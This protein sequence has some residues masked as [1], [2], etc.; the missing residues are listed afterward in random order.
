MMTL[1]RRCIFFI[2][3]LLWVPTLNA[4]PVVN[5]PAKRII[6]L[7]PHSVELLFLLDAGERIIATTSFADYPEAAKLIPVIG[8]YNGIQI[9]KVLALKPDLI[10]A[11][12]G[13]N[14]ADDLAQLERLGFKVYRSQTRNLEGIAD[15]LVR[16]GELLGLS[17]RA[18]QE[19]DKFTLALAEL[20]AN[21]VHK[22]KLKFFYQ[23]WNEP[24]RA[25]AG[26]SWINEMIEICGG[27]NI[28]DATIGDYPQVSIETVLEG[29]PEVI[30]IPSHHGH[31]LGEGDFWRKW[32]EIPAVKNK[33][34]FYVDG[35]ILHRFSVRV[36][37]GINTVCTHFDQVRSSR[38]ESIN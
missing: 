3:V 4:A 18:Q 37:Q 22:E 32:P 15:E 14:K 20:K 5:E 10:I 33:H 1:L 19:A 23:L 13:G 30:I 8:G 29:Q 6:A 38:N 12:E 16:L 26:K 7:S 34:I 11:W 27:Q 24:L 17:E 21:N 31:G 36:L 28:F 35:D 25:M 9:E 2:G